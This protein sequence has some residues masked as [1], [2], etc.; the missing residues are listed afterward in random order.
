MLFHCNSLRR[1]QSLAAVAAHWNGHLY[2]PGPLYLSLLLRSCEALTS[3]ARRNSRAIFPQD[4]L[5]ASCS[6]TYRTLAHVPHLSR[7]L[8]PELFEHVYKYKIGKIVIL[9]NK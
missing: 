3:D 6:P 8:L 4:N 1:L 5:L 2:T 9:I 7:F